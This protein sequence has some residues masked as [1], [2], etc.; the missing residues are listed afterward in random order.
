MKIATTLAAFSLAILARGDHIIETGCPS[1]LLGA[2]VCDVAGN[3]TNVPPEIRLVNIH[4]LPDGRRRLTARVKED[5]V[6][7]LKTTEEALGCF[8]WLDHVVSTVNISR[9]SWD[10][11]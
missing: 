4:K 7:Y 2:L 11:P 3:Y 6:V 8:R 10:L 5:C 1:T 9:P